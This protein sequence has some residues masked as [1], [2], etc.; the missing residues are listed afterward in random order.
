MI[1]KIEEKLKELMNLI[2]EK[3]YANFIE[4]DKT[5]KIYDLVM[6]L[7]DNENVLTEEFLNKVYTLVEAKVNSNK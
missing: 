4:S 3:E 2:D 7:E 5:L 6:E 1:G